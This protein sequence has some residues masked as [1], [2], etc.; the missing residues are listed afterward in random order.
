M[1]KTH[2]KVSLFFVLIL[3]EFSFLVVRVFIYT[4]DCND[5]C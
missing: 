4:E 3:L 1:Q 5:P 2:P